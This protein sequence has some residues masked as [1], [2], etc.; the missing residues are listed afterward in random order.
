[1]VQRNGAK[2]VHLSTTEGKKKSQLS[3]ED[4]WER[5]AKNPPPFSLLKAPHSL[6]QH[7]EHLQD[8]ICSTLLSTHLQ[9]RV[10]GHY[11]QGN[12]ERQTFG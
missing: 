6:Q 2:I 1:M 3:L 5:G 4:K 8:P 12:Q 7:K 11:G 9:I 10:I